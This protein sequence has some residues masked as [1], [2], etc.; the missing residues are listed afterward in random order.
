MNN[1]LVY[2]NADKYDLFG[3]KSI[4]KERVGVLAKRSSAY[5]EIADFPEVVKTV[6]ESTPAMDYGLRE[7]IIDLCSRNIDKIMSD[8]N[9]AMTDTIQE[10]GSL[11]FGILRKTMEADRLALDRAKYSK[12]IIHADPAHCKAENCRNVER[13]FRQEEEMT[14]AIAAKDTAK[15]QL[16]EALSQKDAAIA[17]YRQLE[18]E[19]NVA[20]T[21]WNKAV[22]AQKLAI[23]Q[24]E[25][26]INQ[27]NQVIVERDAA[28]N[29]AS[30]CFTQLDYYLDQSHKWKKCRNCGLDVTSW[31]QRVGSDDSNFTMQ[32]RCSDCG[33]R[34]R[35][36][37]VPH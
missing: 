35:L 8:G 25:F 24:T 23:R 18:G 20:N 13:M 3:L 2:A 4:A 9:T 28:L 34:H 33:C 16:K 21:K 5:T 26:A 19:R 29:R 1:V 17:Q 37:A 15:T 27:R 11:S 31:L 30:D 10:I 14:Q 7:I 12:T 36:G 22:A 32:L 6:F